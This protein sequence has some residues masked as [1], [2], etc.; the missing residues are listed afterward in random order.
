MKRI[1]AYWEQRNFDKR[2]LEVEMDADDSS[3][4][5]AALEDDCANY[6]YIVAKVPKH[7]LDLVHGL[8]ASGFRFMETQ[9]EMS[10]N[11]KKLAEPSRFTKAIAD[12]IRFQTV[13]T[14]EHLE[15]LLSNIDEDLF[16]TDRVSLDPVL[17]NGIAHKRYINWIRDGFL[18][19]NALII[20]AILKSNK[21]GFFYFTKRK[22]KTI[23]AV[24]A[25]VYKNAR[26]RAIGP[27]FLEEICSWLA[28]E[29]YTK[30]TTRVS[31]NNLESLR[32]NLFVGFEMKEIYY[33]L[34]KL[35]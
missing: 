21:V 33:I 28:K 17:G 4:C 32:A 7:R 20:E 8:E 6:E 15:A 3:D 24:L 2:V 25:S 12:H 9:M 31:S 14:R 27:S 10:M 35:T 26:R 34:R 22:D 5:L 30:I 29:G 23:H 16:V 19:G 18:S 13:D 1:D 11:L